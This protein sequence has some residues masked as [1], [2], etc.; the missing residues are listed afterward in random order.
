[1]ENHIVSKNR[2][3]PEG[4]ATPNPRRR[5]TPSTEKPTP[6]PEKSNDDKLG[7]AIKNRAELLRKANRGRSPL[8]SDSLVTVYLIFSLIENC[9]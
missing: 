3:R 7:A 2:R 4:S 6:A 8:V 1:V 5:A 9:F